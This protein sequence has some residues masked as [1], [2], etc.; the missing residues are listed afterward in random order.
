LI[1]VRAVNRKAYSAA[2]CNISVGPVIPALIGKD[3]H[4]GM[5]GRFPALVF[6]IHGKKVNRK[7][8]KLYKGFLYF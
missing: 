5:E 1:D 6:I 4:K 8:G 3:H 2:L 7:K